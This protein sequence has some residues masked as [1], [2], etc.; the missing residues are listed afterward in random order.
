MTTIPTSNFAE[1]FL[2]DLAFT[3]RVKTTT[4]IISPDAGKVC[5][6]TPHGASYISRSLFVVDRRDVVTRS[7]SWT[8]TTR[9]TLLMDSVAFP[10]VDTALVAAS[11]DVT[12]T[13]ICTPRSTCLQLQCPAGSDDTR[14]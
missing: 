8:P 9:P 5:S 11:V 6:L 12:N 13:N 1:L 14:E 10:A 7:V 2:R 3:D 4:G